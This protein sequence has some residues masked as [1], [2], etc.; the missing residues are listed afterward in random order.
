MKFGSFG[1]RLHL[2]TIF[3]CDF[4]SMF[5][6][7]CVLRP[8]FTEF[9]QLMAGRDAWLGADW[10]FNRPFLLKNTNK[11]S[12]WFSPFYQN[13][14]CTGSPRLIETTL[15]LGRSCSVSVCPSFSNCPSI[16]SMI[17]ITHTHT[18]HSLY[19]PSTPLTLSLFDFL[20]LYLSL[21][22]RIFPQYIIQS[23]SFLC[24][25]YRPQGIFHL[26][27]LFIHSPHHKN[28]AAKQT[29]EKITIFWS[30][31]PNHIDRSPHTSLPFFLLSD[32][33]NFSSVFVSLSH[34]HAVVESGQGGDGPDMP[35]KVCWKANIADTSRSL[36]ILFLTSI[37]PWRSRIRSKQ[38]L[39][40]QPGTLATLKIRHPTRN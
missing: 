33:S 4:R 31:K 24:L 3:V 26:L 15:V 30:S 35:S 39:L 37:W 1:T 28:Q 22:P 25:W 17:H 36:Y 9:Y 8:L 10:F 7:D 2:A 18:P 23:F 32:C 14:P 40:T 27:Y 6:S 12:L 5:F 16:L 13:K 38:S 34:K 29:Q 19:L 11:K 21:T 20:S